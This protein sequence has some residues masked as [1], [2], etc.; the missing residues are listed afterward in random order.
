M[1]TIETPNRICYTPKPN[2]LPNT[3]NQRHPEFYFT[4]GSIVVRIGQT[5]FKVHSS[6]LG[7]HSE[8]FKD[9]ADMP[10]PTD[11]ELVDGCPVVDLQ[12]DVKEFTDTLKAIY[13]PMYVDDHLQRLFT[14]LRQAL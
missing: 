1:A 8:I 13:D 12:D 10:Q 6:I 4:D 7:L 9:M 3:V 5:T 11:G 2:G 14:H